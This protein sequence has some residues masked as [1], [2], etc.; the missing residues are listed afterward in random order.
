MTPTFFAS[1]ELNCAQNDGFFGVAGESIILFAYQLAAKDTRK[2]INIVCKK[3][4][5]GFDLTR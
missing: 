5:R 4:Y 3:M 2:I 1:K